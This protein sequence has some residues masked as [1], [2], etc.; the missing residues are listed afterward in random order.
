MLTHRPDFFKNVK[1]KKKTISNGKKLGR[2][3]RLTALS[4]CEQNK[5]LSGDNRQT[6]P[7]SATTSTY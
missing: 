2:V 6:H 7:H 4:H 1:L 3:L 5:G